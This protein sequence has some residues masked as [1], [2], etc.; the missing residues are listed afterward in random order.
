MIKKMIPNRV[1]N[2][3]KCLIGKPVQSLQSAQSYD[4]RL[5]ITEIHK[6]ERLCILVTGGTGGLG[7]AICY[8][9]AACGAVVGMCGRSIDKI[10]DIIDHISKNSPTVA[11]Q[12]VPIVLDVLDEKQIELA[13][14]DFVEKIGRI[15]VLI[16]NAGGQPGRVGKLSESFCDAEISQIDLI[17]NTNLRG[18]MLCSRIAAR[19]LKEQGAGCIINVGSVIGMGGKSGMCDYAAAKAGVIGF[20]KS[21]ALELGKYNVRVNCVSPGIVHQVPFEAGTENKPSDRNVLHRV[22]YTK[23]VAK[24]IC[25]LIEN[26]YITGQNYAI[27]GG[28]SIGLYGDK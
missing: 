5:D 8:E 22:G 12:I 16:N 24:L 19:Y 10:S 2:A 13:I 11:K 4:Y 15:D 21:L 3:I 17:L 27:D 28:R 9:L 23:E 25:H 26:E 6:F 7:S 20:T 1:K 14:N 18:T